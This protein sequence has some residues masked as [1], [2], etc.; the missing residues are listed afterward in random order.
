MQKSKNVNKKRAGGFLGAA[1]IALTAV[2]IASG[3]YVE[4][5]NNRGKATA[6]KDQTVA[7]INA[8][9]EARAG[10]IEDLDIDREAGK[11]VCKVG[12]VADD[13]RDYDVSI[14]LADNKVIRNVIDR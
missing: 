3:V 9:L 4:A 11:V 12:I 10:S 7:C 13:G 5:Q 2:L 6:T 8:A 14:D 1:I